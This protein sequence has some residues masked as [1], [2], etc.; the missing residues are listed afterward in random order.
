MGAEIVGIDAR[1]AA[2]ATCHTRLFNA[3]LRC[4]QF[5]SQTY[6]DVLFQRSFEFA[7]ARRFLTPFD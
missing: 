6:L 4:G 3:S 5:F 1:C 7:R 2:I